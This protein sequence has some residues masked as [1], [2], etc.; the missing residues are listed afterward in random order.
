MIIQKIKENQRTMIRNRIM[1]R[2]FTRFGWTTQTNR[3]DDTAAWICHL[4]EAVAAY[5]EA[6]VILRAALR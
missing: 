2:K 1:I 4:R 6:N 5:L 3:V